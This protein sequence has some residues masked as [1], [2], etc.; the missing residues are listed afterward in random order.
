MPPVPRG[1]VRPLLGEAVAD[2][3]SDAPGPPGDQGNL[4]V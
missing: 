4:V 2:G 3:A 1:D